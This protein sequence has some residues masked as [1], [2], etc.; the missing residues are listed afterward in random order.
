MQLEGSVRCKPVT[1]R[2]VSFGLKIEFLVYTEASLLEHFEQLASL[3]V[4]LNEVI[5]VVLAQSP[6]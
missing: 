3:G 1:D 5:V 2:A 4:I 6:V